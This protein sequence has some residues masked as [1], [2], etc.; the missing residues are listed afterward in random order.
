MRISD[1]SSDVCSSDLQYCAAT[2]ATVVDAVADHLKTLRWQPALRFLPPYHDDPAYLDALKTS[3]ESGL[4]A[5][6]FAPDVLLASFHGMPERTLHLGDP[7]PCQ[8]RTT[9]RLLS[10]LLGRP[11]GIGGT[12]FRERCCPYV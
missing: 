11:T 3:V 5:L 10:D 4:A 9:A 2:T 1:W 8:C 7:Y 12:P 6:D